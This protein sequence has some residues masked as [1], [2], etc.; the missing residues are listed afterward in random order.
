[1]W[2]KENAGLGIG[3]RAQHEIILHFTYGE[4][5]YHDKSC[6]NVLRVPRVRGDDREHQT[7]KPV[8]LL[9]RLIRVV[10]PEGGTVLDP[11]CGSGSTGVACVLEERSFVGIERAAEHVDTARRRIADTAEPLK[12]RPLFRHLDPS[13]PTPP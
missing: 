3:F 6:G 9:R 7:Q 5:V 4:P 13:T 1:V 11:F 8:D 10:A 2:D 12:Q